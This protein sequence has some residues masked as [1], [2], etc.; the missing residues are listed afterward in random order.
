MATID[1]GVLETTAAGRGRCFLPLAAFLAPLAVGLA[2]GGLL[3]TSDDGTDAAEW[4]RAGLVVAW[5]LAGLALV[6]R[7]ALRRLGTIVLVANL[8]AV[9]PARSAARTRPAVVLRSE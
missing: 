1:D 2:L 8:V 6:V 5:A 4:V 3:L 7:P 9:L